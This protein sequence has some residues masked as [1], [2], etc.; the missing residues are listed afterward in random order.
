MERAKCE[1]CGCTGN[2]E[3][4]YPPEGEQDCRLSEQMICACCIAG[5]NRM[6]YRPE[7]DG[8]MNLLEEE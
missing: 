8:Q 1:I 5:D 2:K 4:L 6:S 3:C 7:E